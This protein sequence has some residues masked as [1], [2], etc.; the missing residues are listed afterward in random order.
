MNER[1]GHNGE[2]AFRCLVT[3]ATG[4][5]GLN[6]VRELCARGQRVY[7]MV[8]RGSDTAPLSSLIATIAS[9]A[10]LSRSSS[11]KTTSSQARSI[12]SA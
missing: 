4:F 6:L 11:E 2:Q 9:P 10:L 12:T 5:I 7:C 8:R 3:G 1:R